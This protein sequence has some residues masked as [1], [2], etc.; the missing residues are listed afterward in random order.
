MD[1]PFDRG[2]SNAPNL[3][4]RP[5]MNTSGRLDHRG[6]MRGYGGQRQL[7]PGTA[8]VAELVLRQVRQLTGGAVEDR[9]FDL[10]R[11]VERRRPSS[12]SAEEP[13]GWMIRQASVTK[14]IIGIKYYGQQ[15]LK[16]VG[17]GKSSIDINTTT[18]S[19]HLES[20]GCSL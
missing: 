5:F 4:Q 11:P 2:H 14:N 13:T 18:R 1:K 6:P 12:L 7:A 9:E 3:T 17:E 10:L 20:R 8:A 19:I 16:G 15:R